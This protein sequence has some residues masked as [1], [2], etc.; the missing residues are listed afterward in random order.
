MCLGVR[1]RGSEHQGEEDLADV[2]KTGRWDKEKMVRSF[3]RLGAVE[4]EVEGKAAADKVSR[5]VL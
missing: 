2:F 5:V 4:K 1:K 3:A